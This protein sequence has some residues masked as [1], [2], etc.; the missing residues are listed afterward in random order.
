MSNLSSA[1]KD[2]EI[3]LDCNQRVSVV[4]DSSS[5]VAMFLRRTYNC[6]LTE[7]N[8]TQRDTGENNAHQIQRAFSSQQKYQPTHQHQYMQIFYYMQLTKS[9]LR[10]RHSWLHPNVQCH[11]K[12]H[13]VTKQ[14]HD[15]STRYWDFLEKERQPFHQQSSTL[16]KL[17]IP[18]FDQDDQ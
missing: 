17:K 2:S 8:L 3:S 1:E 7:S 12:L 15:S 6:V 18:T 14:E 4:L 11:Q 9:H 13:Q 10:Q 16:D 5:L